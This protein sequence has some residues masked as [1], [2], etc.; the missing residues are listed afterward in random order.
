MI[1]F[2]IPL[3]V[4]HVQTDHMCATKSKHK[5]LYVLIRSSSVDVH[6]L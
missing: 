4:M 3:L 6:V 1:F 2:F 5:S